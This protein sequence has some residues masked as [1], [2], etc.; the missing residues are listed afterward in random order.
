MTRVLA[1]G[2]TP[3]GV[4]AVPIQDMDG[5]AL[6]SA[7][8][9]DTAVVLLLLTAEGEIV[10][11]NAEA[12]QFFNAGTNGLV[13]K[14]YQDLYP[15][16]FVAER[17]GYIAEVAKT[18][19]HITLEGIAKGGW[20]RTSLRR[21][22]SGARPLVLLVKR[23]GGGANSES[24]PAAEHNTSVVRTRVHDL[25]ALGT[26]TGREREILALIGQGLSTSEIA[27][28][29]GR[30]VKTIEWHRVSLGAKLGVGNRVELA[31]IAI[32]AGLA[33]LAPGVDTSRS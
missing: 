13:G 17:M 25:G 20:R 8:T 16:E 9:E 6:W 19:R 3:H 30:S 21:V 11:A 14:R 1:N 29:L 10:A 23:T 22:A 15:P 28:Q 32:R 4:T 7:L 18:G 27:K 5:V 2:S 31:H 24:G 26:L 12:N 33:K